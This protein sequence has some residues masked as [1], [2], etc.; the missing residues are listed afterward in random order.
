MDRHNEAFIQAARVVPRVWTGLVLNDNYRIGSLIEQGATFELYD[1]TQIS[2]NDRECLKILLPQLAADPKVLTLFLEEGRSMSRISHPGLLQYRACARDPQSDLSYIVMD[3][4]GPRLSARLG[5]LK[6]EPRDILAFGK[7]LASALAVAHRAG[8][9]HGH[10]SPESVV[11]PGEGLTDAAIIGFSLIKAEAGA[12]HLATP[13]GEDSIGAWT[14]IRSLALVMVAAS[15]G[16]HGGGDVSVLPRNLRT[17]VRKMLRSGP[18]GTLRSMDDVVDLLH[19][20]VLDS[21]PRQASGR[22]SSLPSWW[23]DPKRCC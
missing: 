22:R 23:R 17:V 12:P 1:G 8:L 11:L 21:E 16:K 3:A 10:L 6:P 5:L 20:V 2:T 18:R 14:D 15:S 13:D 4:P 7:Q 9:V 19:R